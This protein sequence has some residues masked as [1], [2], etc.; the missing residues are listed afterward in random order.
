MQQPERTYT[1]IDD[2]NHKQTLSGRKIKC[3]GEQPCRQCTDKRLVCEEAPSRKRPQK[4]H[5]PV[6]NWHAVPKPNP[7]NNKAKS[8]YKAPLQ[9][10]SQS[11]EN[12]SPAHPDSGISSK[13]ASQ[14]HSRQQQ[15]GGSSHS[16]L[17]AKSPRGTS[18]SQ[19]ETSA[20]DGSQPIPPHLMYSGQ[21]PPFAFNAANFQH[22]QFEHR[23]LS[24]TMS[25]DWSFLPHSGQL[26]H[27][28][29]G[30][31]NDASEASYDTD[32]ASGILSRT[33]S[34]DWRRRS[35][36][37]LWP[38]SSNAHSHSNLIRKAQ[39]LEQEALTL[40]GLASQQRREKHVASPQTETMLP[41]STS[42]ALGGNLRPLDAGGLP[43][44]S[45][46]QAA[47]DIS[48]NF[49]SDGSLCTGMTP[50]AY[51]CP[52]FWDVSPTQTTGTPFR[53]LS[54]PQN[55]SMAPNDG[56]SEGTMSPSIVPQNVFTSGESFQPRTA[57]GD[58]P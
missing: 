17:A 1:F 36:H 34:I 51:E 16:A 26:S 56:L 46:T 31:Q 57:F 19:F 37:P 8:D 4:H 13:E 7:S 42:A 38:S 49:Y 28:Y 5:S 6:P 23:S 43:T 48:A 50:N 21:L 11:P 2:P 32:P 29:A 53:N 3:S 18:F 58:N 55:R 20:K 40:R 14:T 27:A 30:A 33:G 9:F 10:H 12:F 44:S 35:S 54:A 52:S 15:A 25:E 47:P 24:T 41:S 39:A 22:T 45:T